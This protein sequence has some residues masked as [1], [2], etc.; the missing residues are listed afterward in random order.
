MGNRGAR[1]MRG[2]VQFHRA[3][4]ACS[5]LVAA[6]GLMLPQAAKAESEAV[7]NASRAVPEIIVTAR[8]KSELLNNV[9]LAVQAFDSDTIAKEGIRS[10]EDIA[11]RTAGLTFDNG[12]F[13]NDTRPALRGMQA[14]RGRPSVAVLFDGQDLTT[15]NLSIAGGGASLN[16]QLFD[17][18]RI[19][20]VRG[21]QSTVYGRNAFAGA[22]NYI[23]KAPS[24]TL[25]GH[26]GGEIGNGDT[27]AID[28]ALNLPIMR[29][30]IAL[31][32]NAGYRDQ[33]GFYR[34]PVTGAK[35]GSTHAG[36][37][38]AA[39]LIKPMTGLSITGRWTHSVETMSESAT[40]FLS[41]NTRLPAPGAKFGP[42]PGAPATVPC[43]ADLS[44]L[45]PSQLASCTRGTLVGPI[46]ASESTIQLSPDPFTKRAFA[47][48]R[49]RQDLA[50]ANVDW[51]GDWGS[52]GYRF[53][54]L[55]AQSFILQDGDFSNFAAPPGL[56]LSIS[57][58]QDLRYRTRH[59]DHEVRYAGSFGAFDLTAGVQ[60]F[61]ETA[62][63]DN[64]AQFWLRSPTSPLAGPPFN[65]ST[66]PNANFALPVRNTR[67]TKYWGV[68]G[69][70]AWSITKTIKLTADAR[71]ND[72]N[73]TYTIPGWR[74]Q[75]VTL[76]KL[77]PVC[78]PQFANGAVFSP[79]SPATTP[80]PGVVAACARSG[81]IT[82]QKV[83]P[84]FTAEWKPSDAA[85]I[86]ASYAQGFKPGGFNT[87][88]I[89][90]LTGQG[91]RPERVTAYE[92]G[93]KT[94]WLDRSL[95]INANLYYNDYTDQQIGVQNSNVAP[96]GTVTTTAGIVNAGEVKIYGFEGEI[97]WRATQHLRLM[98]SYAYTDAKFKSYIQGPPPGSAQAAFDACGVPSGQTS[99]DQNR[100]EAGNICADFSGR[101]VGRSPKHSLNMMAEVRYPVGKASVF[102][103]ANALYRSKRF[104]DESNL[105]FMP[106]YWRAGL[107]AGVDI[108]SLQVTGYI[109][110]LFD[111][112]RIETAQRNVDFGR[113]EGFAPGR[114]F[115]VTL[116]RPRSF[117]MRAGWRF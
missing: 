78:L 109:D 18:E 45:S 12:G 113:P 110:N 104:T 75:D 73:I 21:P 33:G 53:G 93:A 55:D 36:G 35:L 111:N 68:Y 106:E 102:F 57:A 64:A 80:P 44:M 72:D 43:P 100:A 74:S 24:F 65:L 116:P 48:L 8:K 28:G 27:Q 101:Q 4:L 86:Y 23:S 41:A 96:N 20:V 77:T 82:S 62:A 81:T 59:F 7:D 26:V 15:E 63:L 50:S 90:E 22:I 6:G 98:A 42:A 13:M 10:V 46:Y 112:R 51:S 40:A 76:S 99:S 38:G 39:L 56:V 70:V 34:N 11:R 85:L 2:Q 94:T 25:G 84:R 1:I 69:S 47:G 88:E 108:G 14:E 16:S 66:A 97:D 58:L 103:E 60:R 9:P 89:V 67:E 71:Y 95:I 83:T 49:N 115:N 107:R 5:A 105:A 19:E 54:Y 17:L 91:Y 117:G 114:G 87:N 30:V 37:F 3:L 52:L 92:L 79:F 31:R 61:T 29:D 32:V